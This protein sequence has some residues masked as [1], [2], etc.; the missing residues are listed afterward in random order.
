MWMSTD[1]TP[2]LTPGRCSYCRAALDPRYYFCRRCAT[3]YQHV[4]AVLPAMP[5]APL[6]ERQLIRRKAPHV[7][8]MFWTYVAVVL[9]SAVLGLAFH[10]LVGRDVLLLMQVGLLALVTIIFASLH[11]P[12][13]VPQL[14]RSG[15]GRPAA[16]VAL[17]L[18]GPLL[19]I[20]YLYHVAL[21]GATGLE[22]PL[23][24]GGYSLLA[25]TVLYAVFPAVTEEIAFRGLLQH[26]L[27][28]AIRPWRAVLLAS[29]LFMV[30]HFS[31][32]SAPYLFAV[33]LLLGWARWKTGSLYPPML[34]HFLHNFIVV[35][36]FP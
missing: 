14:S 20:N 6:S 26:W 17:V 7:W 11:W 16:W 32:A 30:M 24:A 1:D 10:G 31:L 8:P 5:P 35:V 19:Y 3:P 4:E 29:A 15:F 9:G 25:V 27:S 36:A 22:D 2:N 13:L 28:A 33:G 23:L 12:S 18:L 21:L 34:L